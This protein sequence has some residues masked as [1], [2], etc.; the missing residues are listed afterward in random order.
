MDSVMNDTRLTH[1]IEYRVFLTKAAFNKM[2]A[3]F[4][5]KLDSNV[6]KKLMKSYI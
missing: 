2:E 1:E 3:L 5:S 6:R 4:N